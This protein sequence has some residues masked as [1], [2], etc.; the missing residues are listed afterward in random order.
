MLRS[1]NEGNVYPNRMVPGYLD[2]YFLFFGY[3]SNF[4]APLSA[5]N[6]AHQYPLQRNGM[7]ANP[8]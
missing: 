5:A 8:K 3:I 7:A 4:L 6:I 2:S 1:V